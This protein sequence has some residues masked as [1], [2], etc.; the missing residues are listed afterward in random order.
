M[1]SPARERESAIDAMSSIELVV[2]L[3]LG[4]AE[5]GLDALVAGAAGAAP[6]ASRFRSGLELKP[7]R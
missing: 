6:A 3:G 1:K 7:A 5:G 2:V 4:H